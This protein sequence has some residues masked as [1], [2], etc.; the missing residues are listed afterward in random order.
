ML[1]SKQVDVCGT[2]LVGYIETTYNKLVKVFGEPTNSTRS[3]DNKTTIEWHIKFDDGTVATIYDYKN[4]DWS[5]SKVK[6]KNR[7]WHIGGNSQ[8]AVT[9]IRDEVANKYPVLT[10]TV[11]VSRITLKTK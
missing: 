3:G 6:T 7:D 8:D 1:V 5:L 9:K 11:G 4:Y 2:C 10:R